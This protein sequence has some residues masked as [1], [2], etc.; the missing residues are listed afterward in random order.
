MSI[1]FCFRAIAILSASCILIVYGSPLKSSLASYQYHE[2][3]GQVVA[4][5]T[6]RLDQAASEFVTQFRNPASIL[7][8][9]LIIGGDIVQKAIA[10]LSGGFITPVSF[11]FGWVSYSFT[12]L[13]SAFGDGVFLP[14][15]D[16]TAK[17]ITI[18]GGGSRK[19]TNLG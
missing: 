13:L 8:V 3:S 16:I 7:D 1:S 6:K 4:S 18:S 9:L 10:Q 12:S 5:L 14:P 15:P 17:V 11:S 19:S 2:H